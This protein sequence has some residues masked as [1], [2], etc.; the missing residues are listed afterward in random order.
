MGSSE[1][2][3]TISHC[4]Y[5]DLSAG[6]VIPLLTKNLH[7]YPQFST[8]PDTL[9]CLTSR[10]ACI[11][12]GDN[13]AQHMPAKDLAGQSRPQDGNNDGSV[14]T[15]MGCYEEVVEAIFPWTMFLP[16]IISKH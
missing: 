6:G 13:S 7:V 14:I 2:S 10:S 15:N 1:S 9:Y 12:A 8:N 5:W 3:L 4:D 11:D 16:A